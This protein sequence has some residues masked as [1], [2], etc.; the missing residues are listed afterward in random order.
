MAVSHLDPHTLPFLGHIDEAKQHVEALL[1]MYP[2]MTVREAD[3]FYELLS[4][5]SIS[6]FQRTK[7]RRLPRSLT[8]TTCWMLGPA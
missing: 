6:R 1:K 2:T 3:A 7:S 8:S 5:G 4:P